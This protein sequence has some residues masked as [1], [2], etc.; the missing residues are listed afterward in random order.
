MM[1]GQKSMP[2]SA[3]AHLLCAAPCSDQKLKVTFV[4][5][6]IDFVAHW[7]KVAERPTW[8]MRLI[9]REKLKTRKRRALSR[10]RSA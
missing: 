2:M 3:D 4:S 1:D 8:S 10:S 9:L 5:V 6:L 7:G